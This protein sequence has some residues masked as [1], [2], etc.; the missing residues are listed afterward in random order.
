LATAYSL[1]IVG[2]TSL[3]GAFTKYKQG[4]V[5]FKTAFIFA[6]PAVVTVIVTRSLLLPLI[7]ATVFTL[8]SL[9]IT[10]SVLLIVIFAILMVFA[11]I[12]M[13]HGNGKE[14]IIHS[15]VQKFD[16]PKIFLQGAF[17]GI[18]TGLVG[19]G[20]GFLIIPALVI[21]SNLPMKKAIATSLLIITINS[22]VGFLGSIPHHEID[23]KLLA[24]V[25]LLAVGGI[26]IGNGVSR[27]VPGEKL[28]EAFGWFV[29]AMGVYI[30]VKEL[31]LTN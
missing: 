16:Y 12:S 14:I 19:A 18:I 4:L 29:L 17:V 7:P 8:G 23:W 10:K 1:F 11:S 13:I 31:F 9:T 22:L 21:F 28:K 26:F 5:N 3:V 20:G 27:K 24:V 6:T 15:R 2:S 30:I 25:T